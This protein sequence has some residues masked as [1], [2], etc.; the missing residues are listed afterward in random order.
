M[1][2]LWRALHRIDSYGLWRIKRLS[3]HQ[4]NEQH[5]QSG[6]TSPKPTKRSTGRR[7][8]SLTRRQPAQQ[9][10]L[11]CFGAREDRR[12]GFLVLA[13]REM[14][15]FI[16]NPSPLFYSR[17]FRAIFDDRSSFFAPKPH[18]SGG[19]LIKDATHVSVPDPKQRWGLCT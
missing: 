2:Q 3:E 19:H 10:F 12:T 9:A 4:K 18:G 17:H 1:Q 14:E 6:N 8:R 11:F 5:P 13:A 16:P 7:S 15:P